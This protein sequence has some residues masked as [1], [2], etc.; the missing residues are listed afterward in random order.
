MRNINARARKFGKHQQSWLAIELR[1]SCLAWPRVGLGWK[2]IS[3]RKIS[4]GVAT[5]TKLMRT[6]SA[7]HRSEIGAPL[8][9]LIEDFLASTGTP[10]KCHIA[11]QGH[12]K[13]AISNHLGSLLARNQDAFLQLLS[14]GDCGNHC[15]DTAATCGSSEWHEQFP[16][17]MH[18]GCR[19]VVQVCDSVGFL[20]SAQTAPIARA[21]RARNRLPTI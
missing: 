10:T 5:R 16:K 15:P 13:V 21:A 3:I 11:G 9:T 2:T 8:Q 17:P 12:P 20:L 6:R 4:G 18:I 19:I 1:A 7:P 14:S